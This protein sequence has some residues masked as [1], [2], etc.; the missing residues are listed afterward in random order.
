MLETEFLALIAYFNL[1]LC[2]FNFLPIPPLDGFRIT[3]EFFLEPKSVENTSV[4]LVLLMILFTS[5]IGEIL[6][7]F[8]ELMIKWL[9]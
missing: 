9:T 6:F 4:G 8:S 1:T 2:L 5:N 3:S 7:E